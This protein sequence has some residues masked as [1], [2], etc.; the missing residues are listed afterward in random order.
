MLYNL[1]VWLVGLI[2]LMPVPILA[3]TWARVICPPHE[4]EAQ[5]WQEQFYLLA[6]IGSSICTLAYVCYWSWRVGLI[7]HATFPLNVLLKLE[8]FVSISRGLSI[9]AIGLM[10]IGRG[11]YRRALLLG[12]A[13]V[14]LNLWMHRDIIHWR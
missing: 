7:Y 1:S 4:I 6:L 11:P 14:S 12:T 3:L 9:A 5:G 13:W 8:W 2:M 10:A